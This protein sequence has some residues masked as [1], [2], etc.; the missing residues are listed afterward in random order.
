MLVSG[1]LQPSSAEALVYRGCPCLGPP[2]PEQVR[3]G[4]KAPTLLWL[5]VLLRGRSRGRGVL[6]HFAFTCVEEYLRFRRLT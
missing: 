3:I 5:L 1:H 4:D 6:V 2:V